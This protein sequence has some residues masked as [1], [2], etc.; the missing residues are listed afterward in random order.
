MY[1]YHFLQISCTYK[2]KSILSKIACAQNIQINIL[3]KILY[4]NIIIVIHNSKLR[5]I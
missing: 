5:A 1:V 4:L 2:K 3:L